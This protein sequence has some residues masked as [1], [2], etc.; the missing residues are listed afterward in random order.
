MVRLVDVK[1]H[2]F[3]DENYVAEV[4]FFQA[5]RHGLAQGVLD[6]RS[7]EFA[8]HLLG[9]LPRKQRRRLYHYEPRRHLKEIGGDLQVSLR[10]S[11]EVQ[12]ELI[13]QHAY[14]D[15]LDIQLVLLYQREQC[16]QRSFEYLKLEAKSLHES[17][18]EER[19]LVEQ[20][21]DTVAGKSERNG[22]HS[23]HEQREEYPVDYLLILLHE[24]DRLARQKARQYVETVERS[25]RHKV[26]YRKVNV[27]LRGVVKTEGDVSAGGGREVHK[28][29][30]V[31][32]YHDI[33][34]QDIREWTCKGGQRQRRTGLDLIAPAYIHR[35]GL[36]PAYA[37]EHHHYRAHHVDVS[38]WV[39]REPSLTFRGVVAKDLRH[40][41]VG[42]LV[43]REHH[44]NDDKHREYRQNNANHL[45]FS[46]AA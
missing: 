35:G 2:R 36:R 46:D 6:K 11:A 29:K 21:H 15:V 3:P 30:L 31:R 17:P 5:L 4:A 27:D 25:D 43:Y 40:K 19:S 12:H 1:L 7:L 10:H 33:A 22:E 26:E 9:F 23:E 28:N 18:E 13:Q 38:E 41:T 20:P 42:A 24:V 34:E 44:E 8:F 32:Y 39:Q 45:G 37:E 16:V 14:L